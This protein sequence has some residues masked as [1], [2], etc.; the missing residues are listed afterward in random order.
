MSATHQPHKRHPTPGDAAEADPE[1]GM[2]PVEPDNG[3]ALPITPTEAGEGHEA[4]P[5]PVI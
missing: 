3:L 2:L 4:D 1:P 5:A